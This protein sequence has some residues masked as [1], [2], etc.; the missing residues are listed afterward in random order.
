MTGANRAIR[1]SAT[2]AIIGVAAIAESMIDVDGNQGGTLLVGSTRG[3]ARERA[4]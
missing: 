1:W 4:R 2:A 3:G